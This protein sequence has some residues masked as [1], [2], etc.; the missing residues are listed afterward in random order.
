MVAAICHWDDQAKLVNLVTRLRG[1][2]YAFYRSCTAQQRASY[3]ALVV[4][5][6]KRFTPVR[7]Q[8]VQSSLFHERKQKPKELVDD[9]AQELRRLF[10]KAYPS[11]QQGSA[12]T[13][14]MG[15]SVLAYQFVAGLHSDLKMKVAGTEGSFDEL[16]AK[17]RLHEAKLR[18]LAGETQK[19]IQKKPNES[20]NVHTSQPRGNEIPAGDRSK[21]KQ[22]GSIRCFS[23]GSTGHIARQCRWRGSRSS[24]E[25]RGRNR[26]STDSKVA[27]ISVNEGTQQS[28]KVKDTQETVAELRR[29]LREAEV[30]EAL[31]EVVA[32][33]HGVSPKEV[34]HNVC[35][36]PT[37][38][39]LVTFEGT[40]V[41]ASLDTGSPV[42]IVSLGFAL[43]AMAKQ[44][45]P[46]QTPTDWEEE[47]KSRLL[48]PTLILQNYGGGE[49]EIVRQLRATVA[50]GPRVVEALLQVQ[51][52]APV[53]L[54]IGTDLQSQLGFAFLEPDIETENGTTTDLLSGEP[55][56]GHGE[57]E[58]CDLVTSSEPLSSKPNL[59]SDH[60]SMPTVHLIQATRLPARHGKHVR[61]LVEGPKERTLTV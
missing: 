15:K 55:W 45:N 37:I 1:Q 48:P 3:Q 16:L 49:I 44:R 39:A 36:G 9:Y 43:G 33:L 8:A 32:T 35:L 52:G 19:A 11:A 10:H 5:L 13:E 42:T 50:K 51:N 22:S 53:D 6:T 30:E 12:E 26:S 34:D 58:S 38:T 61:A 54:L 18:D 59:G 28:K 4:E 46:S 40:P 20:G 56:K 23:C 14:S 31:T 27:A 7:L 21:G 17:A 47:V 60:T 57:P 41:R 29:K 25:A 2:A 24:E